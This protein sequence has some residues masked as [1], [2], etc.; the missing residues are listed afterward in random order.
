MDEEYDL[1]ILGT[2]L[3][4]CILS[5][6]LSIEG[7][8]VLH[9]DR[10]KY[11]GGETASISP[12]ADLYAM[13]EKD[14]SKL[15][16]FGRGRDWNV[17]LIPKFLM[18]QGRLAKLL[19]ASEVTRYVNFKCVDGSY[20]YKSGTIHKVPCDVKEALSTSL[21]GIFEKRRFRKLLMHCVSIDENDP[22]TW[23]G[24]DIFKC[25]TKEYFAK[26]SIDNNTKDCI[27]H[28]IALYLNDDY[29]VDTLAIETIRRMKLY[30]ESLAA[31]GKSPYLYP[32]Y[33]L[34]DLPQ[35]FARLSAIHGGLY[36]LDKPVDE[37]VFEEG[38]VCG[39]KSG[40]E[41]VRCKAVICDP[42]YYLEQCKEEGKVIRAICILKHP[43]PNTNNAQSC[44]IILP[45][46][47]IGRQ[48]DIY[49]CCVSFA[50]EVAASGHY[51]A[52]VATKVET[53]NP[54]SELNPG[55]QL[56][57]PI[58]E[59]FYN[60]SKYYVPTDCGRSNNVFVTRSYDATTHFETTCQDVL[61]V[62]KRYTG[63]DFDFS[64]VKNKT[65]MCEQDI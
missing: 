15:E 43:I 41:V 50:H 14:A 5:G 53:D 42:S 26:F 32:M 3:K 1:V 4:E 16:G 8:K 49:V 33:G 48:N 51:I 46:N 7:K 47:Q 28:A 24:L 44:Q 30:N 18:A 36:M 37:L 6:L 12:L 9:I 11:Y 59:V 56:L 35:G 31:Y 39:V 64:K 22:K 10:N 61:D 45:Q 34:G 55:L 2:G 29:L 54:H 62:W 25:Q 57:G 27:G 13:F 52:L 21:M 40:S 19:V 65:S 17:D 63:D 60:V 20:V 58:E 38:K 23:D